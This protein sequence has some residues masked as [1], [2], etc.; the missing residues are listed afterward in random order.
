MIF[1]LLCK[2]IRLHPYIYTFKIIY[3]FAQG[4]SISVESDKN[5]IVLTAMHNI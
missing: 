3:T 5:L 2:D 1:S 4:Q